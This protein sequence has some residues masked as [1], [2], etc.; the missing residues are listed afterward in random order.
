MILATHDYWEFFGGVT[1]DEARAPAQGEGFGFEIGRLSRFDNGR[2]SIVI[3][4]NS[5][6]EGLV[7]RLELAEEI[8]HG[9]NREKGE[10]S[11]ALRHGLT[12]AEFHAELFQRIIMKH[13]DGGYRFLTV[14]NITALQKVIKELRK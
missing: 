6:R 8:Q 9:L 10:A 13:H 1:Q 5:L 12:N 14:D 7:N 4:K 3:A 2:N 11:R